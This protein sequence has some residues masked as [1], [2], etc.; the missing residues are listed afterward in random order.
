MSFGALLFTSACPA[1][2]EGEDGGV[3]GSTGTTSAGPTTS[4]TEV[5]TT[6]G[7][8]GSEEAGS[9]TTTTTGVGSEDSTTL[10][11]GE[12]EDSTTGAVEEDLDMQPEDFV[13]VLEWE[14]VLKFR[15]TNLL[16]HTDEAIAV[17]NSPSGGVYPV[18]TVISLLP[19]EVFV[20]RRAGFSPETSDW[21]F[22]LLQLS[23]SGTTI[24]QRGTTG[25]TTTMGS[26][27][28]SC[29]AQAQ[30]QWDLICH[31]NHGCTPLGF[32]PQFVDQQ[33]AADPRCP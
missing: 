5:A 2:S 18:G 26:T 7:E 4:T 21:E 31:E 24:V 27:C 19:T 15:L 12:S 9:T 13:C 28:I 1:D 11:T 8:P 25:V 22:F 14:K 32:T 30:P 33:Q 16:G 6:T 23:P 29:H 3:G 20:K 10:G 17:A